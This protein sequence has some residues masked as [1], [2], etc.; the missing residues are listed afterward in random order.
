MKK[1]YEHPQ[2]QTPQQETP[3][4]PNWYHQLDEDPVFTSE[5]CYLLEGRPYWLLIIP[6]RLSKLLV[7]GC[8]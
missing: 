8:S 5:M 7:E 1:K 3:I 4:T 2:Q 6:S